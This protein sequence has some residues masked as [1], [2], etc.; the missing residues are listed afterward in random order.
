M[1]FIEEG[2][3]K[4]IREYANNRPFLDQLEKKTDKLRI[5]L[6]YKRPHLDRTKSFRIFVKLVFSNYIRVKPGDFN[7]LP[8]LSLFRSSENF[9]HL[10]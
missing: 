4:L 6:D 9:S 7:D 1:E 5:F 8:N 2:I 3:N 10:D